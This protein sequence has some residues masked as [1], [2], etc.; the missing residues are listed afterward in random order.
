MKLYAAKLLST[1]A[2][3][4]SLWTPELNADEN[5]FELVKS[6]EV[7][8]GYLNPLRGDKSPDAANL[9]GDRTVDVATGML[10]RFN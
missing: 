2:L 4:L 9:W 8:W 5:N 7:K 3:T 6:S 1:L 10:V